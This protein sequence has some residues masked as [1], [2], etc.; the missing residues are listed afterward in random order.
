VNVLRATA[1]VIQSYPS[2]DVGARRLLPPVGPEFRAATFAS[3]TWPDEDT[4]WS[5]ATVDS[6]SV[7][8]S[9]LAEEGATELALAATTNV[10]V[11]RSYLLVDTATTFVVA[12]K[13]K[14][15]S[16][17]YL[18]A[19]LPADVSTSALLVGWAVTATLT[20]AQTDDVGPGIVQFRAT[21]GGV[22]VSWTEAFRVVRRHAVIP[23]T[24]SQ[25]VEAYPEIKS[26]HSRQDINLHGVIKA[27]WEHIL[28][29]RVLRR[30]MWPEDIVDA[31]P[32]RPLLAIACMLHVA[33]MRRDADAAAYADRWQAEFDRLLDN[34][35]ARL[36]WHVE[37]QTTASIPLEPSAEQRRTRHSFSRR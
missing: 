34:T 13:A 29:P 33:R 17:V 9:V 3:P 5:S 6:L 4:G 19:P 2:V 21:V 36:D 20:T 25:L 35:V 14:D 12:I 7:A 28:M 10:V 27:A 31:E 15:A 11:G 23:L 24:P 37:P 22:L 16:R 1:A 32:L 26:L 8:V 30:G 18:E